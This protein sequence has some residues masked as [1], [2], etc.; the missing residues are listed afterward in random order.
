MPAYKTWAF[1]RSR[2]N[3]TDCIRAERSRKGYRSK[4]GRVLKKQ[5]GVMGV[6]EGQ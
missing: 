3:T 4:G 1:G 2:H 5:K 6:R